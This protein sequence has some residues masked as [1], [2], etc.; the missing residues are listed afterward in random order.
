MLPESA[1]QARC[2]RDGWP[3]AGAPRSASPRRLRPR[4]SPAW[5][6]GYDQ[7]RHD[8]RRD[9]KMRRERSRIPRANFV[10]IDTRLHAL[11]ALKRGSPRAQNRARRQRQLPD[12]VLESAVYRAKINGAA[13]QD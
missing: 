3:A 6:H 7:A 12:F 9:R 1:L 4:R 5:R 10:S 2:E 8:R 11:F 13:A